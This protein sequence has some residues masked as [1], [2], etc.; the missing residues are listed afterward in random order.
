L[1]SAAWAEEARAEAE[2]SLQTLPGLTGQ[3][4]EWRFTAPADLGLSGPEPAPSETLGA[5][6]LTVTGAPPRAARQGFVDGRPAGTIAIPESLPEGVVITDLGD[7]LSTHEGLLRERLYSLVGFDTRPGAMNAAR[8]ESGTLVYVPR[9][10]TVDLP[11][12]AIHAVT[13]AHGRVFGRTLIVADEGARLALV[14]RFAGGPGSGEGVVQASSVAEILVG[15]N[16]VVDHY[17]F[18]HWDPGVRHHLTVTAQVDRDARFR[19]MVVTLGGDV[20]RVE[21]TVVL[22]GPGASAEALGLYFA[23]GNQHFEHRVVSRHEAPHAHSNLLYKGAIQ[24]T[25]HTIF[26][27]NLIVRPG[28]SGTDAYQTNRNLVL[29]EGARADTIPFL[30]IETADVRCSHAGAVGRV[31]DEQL[32][33]LES[34]GVP[35]DVAKKL[36]VFGFFQEVLGKL[37]LEDLHDELETAVEEKIRS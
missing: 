30:E 12:E 34:R 5:A 15:P 8:W 18:I 32:F 1:A 16:A 27:G 23:A 36:I 4:E 31:D 14:D 22:A 29:N 17:A 2:R 33:Y 11:V 24:D 19:S 10:A 21:P 28:A 37:D 3:E 25:A 9:G 6:A 20:V 35:R 26:Y 7:A 13:G